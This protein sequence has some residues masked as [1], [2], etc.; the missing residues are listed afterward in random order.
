MSSARNIAASQVRE[1]VANL[2]ADQ[3]GRGTVGCVVLQDS[4]RWSAPLMLAAAADCDGVHVF[5]MKA[6]EVEEVASWVEHLPHSRRILV[7][8]A[9]DL[10]QDVPDLDEMR[11]LRTEVGPALGITHLYVPVGTGPGWRAFLERGQADEP[12][13]NVVEVDLPPGVGARFGEGAKVVR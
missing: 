3:F 4:D 6:H 11:R 8:Y 9:M 13:I 12:P 10:L 2:A 7:H 1:Y 5:V